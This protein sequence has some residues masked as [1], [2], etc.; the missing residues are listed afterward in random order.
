MATLLNEDEIAFSDGCTNLI[1]EFR[2]YVWDEKA[3]ERGED[4]PIK[5]YDHAIDAMRYF[6]YTIVR[7]GSGSV[8]ILR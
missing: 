5:Q 7:K 6:C 8:S 1:R 2:S 3:V 4:K